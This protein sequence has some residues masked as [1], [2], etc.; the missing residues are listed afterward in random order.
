MKSVRR[1]IQPFVVIILLSSC[2]SKEV[3]PDLAKQM[4][5]SYSAN[6]VT[7]VYYTPTPRTLGSYNPV[8]SA[9]IGQITIHK[10]D[11]LRVNVELLLQK[12]TGVVVFEDH[13]ECELSRDFDNKGSIKFN[14]YGGQVGAFTV[15]DGSVGYNYLGFG[16]FTQRGHQVSNVS[17]NFLAKL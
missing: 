9:Q 4:Q 14:S 2:R 6:Q 16:S 5:G 13:F 12:Q 1:L 3:F 8:D 7:L 10:I 17:A 11:A 15:D